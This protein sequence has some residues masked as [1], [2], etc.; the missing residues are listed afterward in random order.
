MNREMAAEDQVPAVFD[1]LDGVVAAE[2]HR[3]PVLGGELR[4]DQPCPV[5]QPLADDG[6]AEPVSGGL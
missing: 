3:L 6:G 4:P 2:I 5:V 1:L